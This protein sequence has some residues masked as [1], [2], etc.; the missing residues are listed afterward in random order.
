MNACRLLFSFR[1]R[2]VFQMKCHC[3]YNTITPIVVLFDFD[4]MIKATCSIDP[5][6]LPI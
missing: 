1:V 4:L 5:Q 2:S 3:M 6:S